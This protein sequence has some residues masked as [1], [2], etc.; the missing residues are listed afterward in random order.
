MRTLLLAALLMTSVIALPGASA[1][2]LVEDAPGDAQTQVFGGPTAPA[3]L[4]ASEAADLLSLDIV[5]NAEELTFALAVT[6]LEQ[7]VNYVRYRIGFTWAK[8]EYVVVAY[9]QVAE[10][11][12]DENTGAYISNLDE[13]NE[14]DALADLEHVMDKGKGTFTIHLPKAYLLDERGR[15][16]LLGDELKELRVE[17]YSDVTIFGFGGARSYDRMP[18]GEKTER[19][20]F[21]FGDITAGHLRLD[22]DERV[23][24]SNGGATTFVYQVVVKNT[25]EIDDEVSVTLG[26]LPDGWNGTVQSP[27]RVPGGSER[28]VAVLLSVPFAHEHGG[29]SSV[30]LTARSQRDAASFSS[31]RIGVLHT[32]IP[33]P[34]GHHSELYLHADNFNGGVFADLFPWTESTMNTEAAHDA[35]AKEAS[36]SDFDGGYI[37][38]ISL[39]P[40][41]RMGLD[42][43][44]DDVGT[45]T[46]S[47][48]GRTKTTG[49]VSAELLLT[50]PS[51][52]GDAADGLLLAE[53][54]EVDAVLDLNT[55]TTFK[56]TLTPTPEADYV[57]Y[58]KGQNVLLV[59]SYQ[60]ADD[61]GTICCIGNMMPGLTTADFKMT[62][63]LNEYHDKLTGL[64][65]TAEALELKADGLVEKTGLPGT[66]MTYAFT[67]VNHA[68][69]A[70]VI[71][72]D[73]AG[74]DVDLGT[75]VPEG[76]VELGP[77][78]SRKLTLAVAIPTG[79]N[80]GEEIEVLLF[81][82]AQSDPSKSAIARTKTIIGKPTGEGVATDES[83]LLLA[84]KQAEE[85]ETPGS[86]A[87][88]ALAALALALLARRR[89]S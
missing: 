23:R 72:L 47:I 4:P 32:P 14:W 18:D 71:E 68:A 13:D 20:A 48:V 78:E 44:L 38:R 34:A 40:M 52:D 43:N 53:S 29:F 25:A 58:V 42:F 69:D 85:N 7:Q 55:P 49:T 36:P 81:A 54:D 19:Y 56:L 12:V 27:L 57:S 63:P 82:H 88:L 31:I 89:R 35:D 64:S 22:A 37:W 83:A 70:H 41:L 79:R 21:Q 1:K 28:K 84:A 67:L 50:D 17:A 24:V 3:A 51:S 59:L 65:E 39:A 16:P 86:G 15:Y 5:E 33:Q 61:L 9:R 77:K 30:N 60:S 76:E 2:A 73:L 46:G 66:T 6:S 75:L 11:V 45:L 74:T 62:L 80:E 87:L 10:G 26:D 8:D